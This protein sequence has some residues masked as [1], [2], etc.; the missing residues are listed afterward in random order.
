MSDIPNP[1]DDSKLV[2]DFLIENGL[3]IKI[4]PFEIRRMEDGA[5]LIETPRVAVGKAPPKSKNGELKP[6]VA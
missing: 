3:A 4:L 1:E 5:L 2:N 6:D